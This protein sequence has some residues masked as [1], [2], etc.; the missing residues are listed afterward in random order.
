MEMTIFTDLECVKTGCCGIPIGF[1]TWGFYPNGNHSE[2]VTMCKEC[3]DEL[4]SKINSSVQAL[5]CHF[6]VKPIK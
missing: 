4:W 1:F 3:A 6:V 2:D 5:L